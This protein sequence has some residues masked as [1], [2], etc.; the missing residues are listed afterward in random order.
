MKWITNL[1]FPG[2]A[3]TIRIRRDHLPG[4]KA[5]KAAPF[6]PR[7][8]KPA[9]NSE[10]NIKALYERFIAGGGKAASKGNKRDRGVGF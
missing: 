7:L 5:P 3:K 4:L 1:L 10:D 9:E 8:P 2:T 6:V